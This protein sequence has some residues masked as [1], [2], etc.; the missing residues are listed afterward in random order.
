MFWW[1]AFN[2]AVNLATHLHQEIL[3]AL[4]RF[5]GETK[6]YVSNLLR[7]LGALYTRACYLIICVAAAAI[8]AVVAWNAYDD[9]SKRRE[10]ERVE[11]E[12]QSVSTKASLAGIVWWEAY[13]NCARIGIGDLDKCSTYNGQLLQEK[14]A[15]I[16]AKS[17][18]EAR[19]EYFNLCGRHY[20]DE[21]C[22]RLIN[23]SVYLS[24]Q[25]NN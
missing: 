12:K 17:A 24:Q 11:Q 3:M 6:A 7:P 13:K 18:V 23:R 5:Y 2:F 15:P 16:L 10:V 22:K 25:S 20:P 4:R 9:W 1:K 8:I 14:V 19:D 21:Y